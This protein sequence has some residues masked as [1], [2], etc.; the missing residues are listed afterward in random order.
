MVDYSYISHNYG[1]NNLLI[2]APHGGGK[3]PVGGVVRRKGKRLMDTFSKRVAK[4]LVEQLN[5]PSYIISNIH[6][7]YVDLNRPMEEATENNPVAIDIWREWYTLLSEYITQMREQFPS[8]LYVDIHSHNNNDAIQFGYGIPKKHY[9]DFLKGYDVSPRSTLDATGNKLRE[10]IFGDD[11][12]QNQM[13]FYGYKVF[14]PKE[15]ETYFDG[16]YNIETY[17][18]NGINSVQIELPVTVLKDDLANLS[19]A[20]GTSIARFKQ[21]FID[22]V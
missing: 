2:T 14:K 5:S 12:L 3:S 6:R 15:D 4:N 20:L 1:E 21:V 10:M 17:Y 9:F 22:T 16:G 13:E 11:G 7:K 19:K 8:S 18:G